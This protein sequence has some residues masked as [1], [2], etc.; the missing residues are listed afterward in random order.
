MAI[1]I[2]IRNNETGLV[3]SYH[4]ISAI[5]Q[6]TNDFATIEVCSYLTQDDREIQKIEAEKINRLRNYE[7]YRVYS[8]V[9]YYP[10]PYQD[11]MTCTQAYEY[12]KTL[13]EFKGAKD[14]FDEGDTNA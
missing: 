5:T 4:R 7:P 1:E 2:T 6:A 9:N 12:L 8:T 11:G 14:I 13:D 3:T 10:C